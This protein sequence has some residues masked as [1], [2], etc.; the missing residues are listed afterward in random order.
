MDGVQVDEKDTV[1]DLGDNNCWENA[2]LYKGVVDWVLP[3]EYK[4]DLMIAFNDTEELEFLDTL[5]FEGVSNQAEPVESPNVETPTNGDSG[6]G[7]CFI[8]SIP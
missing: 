6:G 5:S 8:D 2:Y 7:G 1:W 3:G 4:V